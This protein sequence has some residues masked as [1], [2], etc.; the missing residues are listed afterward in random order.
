MLTRRHFGAGAL[1]SAA[2]AALAGR[3]LASPG[4]SLTYRNDV[5][6][7]G[8]LVP[9][10]RGFF[11]LPFGFSY[12]IISTASEMMDDGYFVPGRFD[13]MGCFALDRS[14]VA[15]VRNH[16]LQIDGHDHGPTRGL[17]RLEARLR[18]EPV[19]G[20]DS[21]G[22]VLPGGTSTIVYD[23]ASGR[24][25]SQYLSLAGTVVNCAG[26]PTPSGSWLSCEENTANRGDVEKDHGWVFDVPAAHRGLVPAEPL[27]ALGR[28]RHEAAAVDPA[29]GI[30]YLTEDRVDSLFYRFIPELPGEFARGRLQALALRDVGGG[31]TRNWNG[32][33]F[34][35]GTVGDVRW[36]DLEETDSP[37]DDLR[38]RGHDRG[39]ALF[40]RGEGI[41]RGNGEYYFCC[42]S[43]GAAR[44]GQIMRYIPSP[45][46]GRPGEDEA[47][48]RLQLF[49]ESTDPSVMDYG[50]NIIVAPWG[51]LIVCEDRSGNKVN[52]LK[53]VTPEGR[54]YTFARLHANTELAGACFS[55]D[56]AVMFVNVYDPGKTLALTG[57]WTRRR[58]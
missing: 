16:E 29:T 6:G 44:L 54:V 32:I 47:P 33:D 31:D 35:P 2:F 20:R 25:Q 7:F 49:V 39:A 24:R 26:G 48:P 55:P 9:D 58:G 1:A 3:T 40:A 23:L 5:R 22:R 41:H 50:D 52:H 4:E 19:F 42:T 37:H 46:E 12:R 10:P 8:E 38:R 13:G 27:R 18:R 30:V 51:D 56:G 45:V 21:N 57:P 43:G 28:F 15:L 53:G 17:A 34:A 11:D 14:R 36:I